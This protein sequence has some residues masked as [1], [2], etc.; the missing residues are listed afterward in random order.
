MGLL[1]MCHYDPQ[2]RLNTKLHN[3]TQEGQQQ[4]STLIMNSCQC[5]GN[6]IIISNTFFI[7]V[8]SFN[9]KCSPRIELRN[10]IKTSQ[11]RGPI[12]TS[13]FM[14]SKF[15]NIQV[16]DIQVFF[17]QLMT[18]KGPWE[19]EGTPMNV[20]PH[21][22]KVIPC[23]SYPY[24]QNINKAMHTQTHFNHLRSNYIYLR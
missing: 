22:V 11:N 17:T 6:F 16:Y 2:E 15:M 24:H 9:S 1:F 10:N 12:G 5:D 7:I 3:L 19:L 14:T 23:N 20:N 8:Q 21:Q 13:K 4:L 18:R